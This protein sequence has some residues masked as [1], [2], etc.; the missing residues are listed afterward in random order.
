MNNLDLLLEN[1]D[2]LEAVN[3]IEEGWFKKQKSEKPKVIEP[4]I[5]PD[6]AISK[7]VQLINSNLSKPEFK[8]F[9]GKIKINPKITGYYNE[10][11][12]NKEKSLDIATYDMEKIIGKY[13]DDNEDEF[14]DAADILDKLINNVNE[15]INKDG[16]TLDTSEDSE[17]YG[18]GGLTIKKGAKL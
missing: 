10:F 14:W 11:I 7:T 9:K 4:N 15:V 2:L 5:D 6:K 3:I 12:N 8:L 17:V 18:E 1:S 13:N 16:Y